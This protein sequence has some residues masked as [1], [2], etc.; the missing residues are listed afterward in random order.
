MGLQIL[1]EAAAAGTLRPG[2]LVTEGTAGSTGVSLA[3]LS[4]GQGYR[5]IARAADSSRVALQPLTHLCRCHIAM[6]DDAS[7]EKAQLLAAYGAAV[8]R[9]RP[10]A[11]S[12][13]DHFVHRCRPERCL[14]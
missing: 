6:P 4:S 14:M 8:E 2:G 10:V 9:V 1:Q 7:A 12:H 3:M 13:P 5:W 11:F